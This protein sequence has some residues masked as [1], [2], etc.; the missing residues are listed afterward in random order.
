MISKAAVDW[1]AKQV[2]EWKRANN[3]PES[4]ERVSDSRPTNESRWQHPVP[5][6][7]K[8]NV[9]ASVIAGQNSYTLGMVI[10]NHQGEYI[11]G[12]VMRCAGRVSVLEPELE[13]IAEA[14]SWAQNVTEGEVV[15]ESD[16]LASV[17]AVQ[18]GHENLLE[19]GDLVQYCQDML[20]ANERFMISFVRRQANRVA[21]EVARI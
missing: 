3:K 2:A 5:G 9:D 17:N 4:A 18:K 11:S 14:L 21:H 1:S 10:R 19:L 16:S 7:L 8:L 20:R 13:G 15:I 6:N 12:K